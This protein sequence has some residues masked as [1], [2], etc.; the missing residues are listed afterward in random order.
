MFTLHITICYVHIKDHP[1]V[2]FCCGKKTALKFF[3]RPL[4]EKAS[5][6]QKTQT[7]AS[8]VQ[9]GGLALEDPHK[10]PRIPMGFPW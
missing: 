8:T 2:S 9:P 4:I 3:P 10:K 1:D 6:P 7:L 5:E